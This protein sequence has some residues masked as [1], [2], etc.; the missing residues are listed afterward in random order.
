M[1]EA[2]VSKTL[3][4]SGKYKRRITDHGRIME[5]AKMITINIIFITNFFFFF[6]FF[7]NNN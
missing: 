4:V 6:F 3:P 1:V 7:A 2:A 5:F